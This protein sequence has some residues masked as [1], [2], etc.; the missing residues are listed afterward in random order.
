MSAAFD[1]VV[2]RRHRGQPCRH[3]RSPT[4]ASAPGA[5]RRHRRPRQRAQRGAHR[6]PRGQHVLPGLIDSQ[7]HFRRAGQ[8]A[9]RRT[10]PKRHRRRRA[11]RDHALLFEMPNTKPPDHQRRGPGRQA[12]RARARAWVDHA[13]YMGG[14]RDEKAPSASASLERLRPAAA[15]SRSSWAARPARSWSTMTPGSIASCAR[16]TRRMAG[17]LRG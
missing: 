11:G 12:S 14:A 5:L 6:R 4:S 15:G 17:A 1:L 7:V 3:Q 8:R 2:R 9:L 13:F 16:S 10:S